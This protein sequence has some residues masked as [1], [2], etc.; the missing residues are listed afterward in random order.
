MHFKQSSLKT[1]MPLYST[2]STNDPRSER[3]GAPRILNSPSLSKHAADHS[4]RDL[5]SVWQFTRSLHNRRSCQSASLHCGDVLRP[6]S[7]SK[8]ADPLQMPSI[9]SNISFLRSSSPCLPAWKTISSPLLLFLLA[10]TPG[11]A[12]LPRFLPP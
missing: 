5:G 6:S 12:P 11:L 7:F 1:W 9:N 4:I 3:R 8:P 2:E 10:S